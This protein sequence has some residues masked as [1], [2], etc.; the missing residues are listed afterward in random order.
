MEKDLSMFL[1]ELHLLKASF[2]LDKHAFGVLH[3]THRGGGGTEFFIQNLISQLRQK[4]VSSFVIRPSE[5]GGVSVGS[6]SVVYPHLQKIDFLESEKLSLIIDILD[7]RYIHVHNLFGYSDKMIPMLISL[8]ERKKVKLVVSIHDYYAFCPSLNLRINKETFCRDYCIQKCSNCIGYQTWEGNYS[9][10]N[11]EER[12]KSYGKLLASA[13]AVFVPNI[14]VSRI[15]EKF[16]PEVKTCVLPHD[17]SYLNNINIEQTKICDASKNIVKVAVIGYINIPKGR[18]LLENLSGYIKKEKLPISINII[19]STD[20]YD[21]LLG[22]GVKITGGYESESEALKLLNV[23]KPSL[24]YIPSIWPETFCYTLSLALFS[25]IPVVVNDLGAQSE[26]VKQERGEE[27][28]VQESVYNDPEKLADFF[29]HFGKK[30]I[31]PYT[32]MVLDDL[33]YYPS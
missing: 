8:S 17:E 28:I 16:F 32:P 22:N 25:R 6:N 4:N 14:A 11:G 7:I 18:L 24:I 9:F 10:Q 29:L 23:I 5:T 19:G 21:V 31:K 27:Y 2:K 3:I 33:L 12:I 1:M 20:C 15:I 13:V 26:R 30:T